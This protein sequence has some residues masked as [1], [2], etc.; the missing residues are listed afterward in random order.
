MA[1]GTAFGGARRKVKGVGAILGPR[2]AARIVS[3]RWRTA[4]EAMADSHVEAAKWRY[5][6][7]LARQRRAREWWLVRVSRVRGFTLEVW[8]VDVACCR[9]V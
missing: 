1:S 7:L 5:A 4:A 2:R 3:Q 6:A 8:C 9:S